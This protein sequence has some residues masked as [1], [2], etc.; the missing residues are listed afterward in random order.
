M[1]IREENASKIK[2]I[3]KRITNIY[4][5]VGTYNMV[6]YSWNKFQLL[7]FLNRKIEGMPKFITLCD[8]LLIL[9][10]AENS[11]VCRKDTVFLN[12]KTDCIL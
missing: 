7:L 9:S 8:S 3:R 12:F 5:Y 1:K 2:K 6:C 10:T 4:M 11:H